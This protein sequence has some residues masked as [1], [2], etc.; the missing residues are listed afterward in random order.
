MILIVDD[1][2]DTRR[3]LARLLHH[4]GHATE[5]AGGGA[6]ALRVRRATR[7]D[8]VILDYNMPDM[9]GLEVLGEIRGSASLRDVPVIMFTAIDGEGVRE[10]AQHLGVQGYVRK[11]SLDWGAFL[12][13][14][15]QI[16]GRPGGRAP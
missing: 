9:N 10:S 12:S 16:V 6:E 4:C 3:V 7:P 1:H 5:V 13:N 11:G 14:M 8:L 2:E 15:E